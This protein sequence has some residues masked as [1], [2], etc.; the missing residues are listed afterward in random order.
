MDRLIY[1]V[2]L[3]LLCAAIGGLLAQFSGST[4]VFL[5]GAIGGFVAFVM[6]VGY[7]R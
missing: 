7:T 4:N 2:A 6:V 3:A 5:S 1:V